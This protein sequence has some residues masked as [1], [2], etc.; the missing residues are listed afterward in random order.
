MS[1]RKRRYGRNRGNG[2]FTNELPENINTITPTEEYWRRNA[3]E[4]N[5]MCCGKEFLSQGK[6]NRLCRTCSQIDAGDEFGLTIGYALP[7]SDH[8]KMT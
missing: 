1:N 6:H 2:R 8:H 4:K 7:N 5:C 3:A